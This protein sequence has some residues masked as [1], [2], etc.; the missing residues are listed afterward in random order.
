M[1][2]GK[3]LK[4]QEV[5]TEVKMNRKVKSIRCL[6]YNRI[7]GVLVMVTVLSLLSGCGRELK[8]GQ[9]IS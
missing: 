8:E 3:R 6:L 2:E 4:I 1:I 5:R 9:T 7:K